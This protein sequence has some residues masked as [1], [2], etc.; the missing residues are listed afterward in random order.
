MQVNHAQLGQIHKLLKQTGREANKADLVA[1]FTDGREE[2]SAKMTYEEATKLINHLSMQTQPDDCD[3]KRKRL[4]GMAYGI[5][6]NAQ[7]VKA[8]CEKY[9]VY[10]VKKEFN[11]YDS[12]ELSGLI[13]KFSKVERHRVEKTLKELGL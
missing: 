13:S 10:G 1:S 7:F 9:G 2:S 4:I 8:W 3:K 6:A 5:G 12:K 11:K